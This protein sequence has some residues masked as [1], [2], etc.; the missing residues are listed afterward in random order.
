[1]TREVAIDI[2]KCG[3]PFDDNPKADLDDFNLALGVAIKAIKNENDLIDRV[4]EVIDKTYEEYARHLPIEEFGR[5]SNL[6]ALI[7]DAVL[8]LKGGE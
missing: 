5:G 7:K 3:R 8:V 4:L 6:T 1:M 2:L